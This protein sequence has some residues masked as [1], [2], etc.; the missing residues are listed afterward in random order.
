M[1]SKKI[2]PFLRQL[3]GTLL[4]MVLV[5][6]GVQ[7]WQTRNMAHSTLPVQQL[8]TLAGKALPLDTLPRPFL[9]HF[10]AS[11]CPVCKLTA[12]AINRISQ[13]YTVVQI[14]TQSGDDEAAIRYAK[15]HGIPLKYAVNDPDGQLLK[16]FGAQAVPADFFIGKDGKIRFTAVGVGTAWGYRLRLGWLNL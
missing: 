15:E 16:L 1:R 4:L 6:Q 7:W 3:S 5:F 11:W 14:I 13:D 10:T 9:I 12:P 8:Q 2:I